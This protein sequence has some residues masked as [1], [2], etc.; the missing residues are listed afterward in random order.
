M[1]TKALTVPLISFEEYLDLEAQS[2]ERHEYLDGA[3][4]L[5]VGASLTHGIVCANLTR[6]LGDRL[7][8]GPRLLVE[9]QTKVRVSKLNRIYYPDL[10]VICDRMRE[11]DDRM[12]QHPTLVAEVLSET[13][14]MVDRRE[15]ARSYQTIESLRYILLIDP[16][17]RCCERWS[18]SDG[19][20]VLREKRSQL[21]LP[22]LGVSLAVA[23]LFEGV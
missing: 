2:P 3:I 17:R 5:M 15:K 13:T 7:R 6:A 8:G 19:E 20:W 4:R 18:R 23:E 11:T 16:D 14:A 21:D 9:G 10:T 22:E 12:V 1:A